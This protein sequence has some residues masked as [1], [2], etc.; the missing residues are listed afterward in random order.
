ME[1]NVIA[2]INA[3]LK[4]GVGDAYRLEHIKQAYVDN[5]SVWITDSH[6]LDRLRDRYL[7]KGGPAAQAE[8]A[9]RESIHCWKCG[10]KCPLGAN[11]CM[12]C[13]SS[14]FEVGSEIRPVSKAA[15]PA[16]PKKRRRARVLVV[17]L[18]PVL[19]GAA[20][21]AAYMLGYLDGAIPFEIPSL[22]LPELGT[23]GGPDVPDPADDPGAG[24]IIPN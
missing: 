7:A 23:P 20:L 22:E 15:P 2:D 3:L 18:V 17:V 4:M 13:G 19:A 10:K 14:L 21:G 16:K 9:A 8:P 11:F 6:Y 24:F 5:K 1:K 12:V